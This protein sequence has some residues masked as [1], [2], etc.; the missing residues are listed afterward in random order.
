MAKLQCGQQKFR[1]IDVC[2]WRRFYDYYENDTLKVLWNRLDNCSLQKLYQHFFSITC[3]DYVPGR[4][5]L[6]DSLE[7]IKKIA[8]E[9]EFDV[10][11]SQPE[12]KSN[13]VAPLQRYNGESWLVH[14][15]YPLG[16]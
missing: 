8:E 14:P 1:L 9:R 3:C 11:K 5:F 13:P 15:L 2:D 16:Q 6:H 12:V 7:W 4:I 10:W